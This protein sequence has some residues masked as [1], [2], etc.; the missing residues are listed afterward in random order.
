M[1]LLAEPDKQIQRLHKRLRAADRRITEIPDQLGAVI[2]MPSRRETR[3]K[4]RSG[5]FRQ[6][7]QQQA[8]HFRQQCR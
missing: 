5:F 7:I 4:Q 6:N 2:C 3:V 8:F 1:T